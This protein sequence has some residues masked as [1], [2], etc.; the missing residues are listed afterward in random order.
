[1]LHA[2]SFVPVTILGVMFMV[3]EGLTLAGAREIAASASSDGERPVRP[4]RGPAGPDVTGSGPAARP[5]IERA[6]KRGAR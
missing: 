3:S 1:M 4:P 2:I 6:V 5:A